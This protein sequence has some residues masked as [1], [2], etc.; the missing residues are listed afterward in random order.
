MIRYY[1]HEIYLTTFII[2][3]LI[4]SLCFSKYK[5]SVDAVV[6]SEHGLLIQMRH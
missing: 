2:S 6:H 1:L 5:G 4:F 3:H